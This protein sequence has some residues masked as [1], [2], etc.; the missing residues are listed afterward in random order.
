VAKNSFPKSPKSGILEEEKIMP[1][2]QTVNPQDANPPTFESVWATLQ[3]VGRKQEEAAE[4]MKETA[5]LIRE[6]RENLKELREDQKETARLIREDRENLDKLRES[7]KQTSQQLGGLHNSMGDLIETLF[8]PHLCEKFDDYNYN[9]KQM[10]RRVPIYD[11][12]NRL[13]SDIDILLSNTS[14]CMA[15]E[16]KRW[17]ED[18]ADVDEHIK[19]MQLIR[20]YPPIE[21]RG[22]KLFSAIVGAAVTPEAC[23]YAE[24]NGFF[25]LEL[26]G[27]DVRLLEPPEDFQPREW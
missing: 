17:L 24:Q 10:R 15:V 5:Q 3:E 14:V 9:L 20:Q 23:E 19:R 2:T 18:K 12:E 11:D 21:V 25:V 27:E 22:K 13:R 26:T 1:A 4:Q 8:T 16:V 7:Q 6:D